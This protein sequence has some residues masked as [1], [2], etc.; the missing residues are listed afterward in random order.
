[1]FL[2]ATEGSAPEEFPNADLVAVSANQQEIYYQTF[3]NKIIE[4]GRAGE[5]VDGFDIPVAYE[6]TPTFRRA[7]ISFGDIDLIVFESH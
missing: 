4:S 2:D 3:N 7:P 1:M 6:E 5:F